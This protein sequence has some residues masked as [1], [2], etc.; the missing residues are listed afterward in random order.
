MGEVGSIK[1]SKWQ[2]E[3]EFRV[4]DP[5]DIRGQVFDWLVS[6]GGAEMYFKIAK[7]GERISGNERGTG[8]SAG[9]AEGACAI[10]AEVSVRH[11]SLDIIA[12]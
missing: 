9:G 7:E 2:K 1:D 4:N 3:A 10:L 8:S 5:P 11:S 6:K 12:P